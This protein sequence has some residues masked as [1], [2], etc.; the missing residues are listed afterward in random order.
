MANPMAGR[1]FVDD[2]ESS[3]SNPATLTRLDVFF[4]KMLSILMLV[5]FPGP[6]GPKKPKNSPR[7][8]E[9]SI[10]ERAYTSPG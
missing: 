5:L 1:I 3:R 10:S 2:D 7:P 6:L 9:K 8:T 4:S